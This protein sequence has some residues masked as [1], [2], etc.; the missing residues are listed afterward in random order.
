MILVSG[1]AGALG[2]VLVKGLIN[3]GSEVRVLALPGDKIAAELE[4]QGCQIVYGDVSD[5]DSLRGIFDKVQTVLHLAAVILPRTEDLYTRVNVE[6]TRNMVEGSMAAGVKHFVHVSSAAAVDPSSSAY[7]RSKAEA[8]RIVRSQSSMQH[9]IV[10]PTLIYGPNGGQEFISFLNYIKQFRIVPFIGR[11]R[12]MKNPVAAEDVIKGLMAIP[13]NPRSF[14]K[15]YNFS[16]G[17]EICILEMGRLLAGHFGLKRTFL[18]LP[19]WFCRVAAL[20][21]EIVCKNPPLTRYAVSRILAQANL[22]NQEARLELG[23][24]PLGITE[25]LNKYLPLDQELSSS[26]PFRPE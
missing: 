10:R 1:G 26:S 23:Y 2:S 17:E 13:D 24:D 8:E 3:K 21:F 20:V 11:G 12:G 6:G 22:D 16:G 9:T 5:K 7:A 15:T 25:G 18:P 19:V 14:G 4:A